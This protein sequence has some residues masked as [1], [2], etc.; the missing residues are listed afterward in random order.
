[1]NYLTYRWKLWRLQLDLE[2]VEAAYGEDFKKARAKSPNYADWQ[3]VYSLYRLEQDNVVFLVRTL[4]GAWLASRANQLV[5]PGL[6]WQNPDHTEDLSNG[7]NVMTVA[8]LAE[9]R[10]RIR[11]E[12]LERSQHIFNWLGAATGLGGVV[13]AI[14]ALMK[15]G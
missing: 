12:E 14:L 7:A 9:L 2:K 6:D 8:A 3:E 11:K 15:G 4:Q 1:M 10:A 5:I 13:V